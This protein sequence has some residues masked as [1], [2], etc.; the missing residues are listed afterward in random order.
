MKGCFGRMIPVP[1]W[2]PNINKYPRTFI[3]H[4]GI[5]ESGA[6]DDW[7]IENLWW[8]LVWLG[9]CGILGKIG[10]LTRVSEDERGIRYLIEMEIPA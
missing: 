2:G 4:Q 10:R 8:T 5:T 6:R 7:E 1:S 3:S 9:G